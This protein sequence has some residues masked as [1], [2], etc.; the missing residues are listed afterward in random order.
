VIIYQS[1]IIFFFTSSLTFYLLFFYFH[2]YDIQRAI[3]ILITSS[4][5][6]IV[7]ISFINLTALDSSH[8]LELKRDLMDVTEERNDLL[9]AVE[10]LKSGE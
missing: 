6:L 7:F 8:I 4:L 10:H 3:V 9:S 1:P 2:F 5:I